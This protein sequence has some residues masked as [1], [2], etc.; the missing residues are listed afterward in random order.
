MIRIDQFISYKI[1]SNQE[2]PESKTNA[3]GIAAIGES[4]RHHNILIVRK[5]DSERVP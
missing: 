1:Y 2:Q 5:K 3:L 4:V